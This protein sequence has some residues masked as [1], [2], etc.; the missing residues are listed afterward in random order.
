MALSKIQA[1]SMNLA[2][3]YA[4][5]GT[6]SGAGANTPAFRAHLGTNQNINNAS[7]TTMAFD[8][9]D[10]DTDN[11][12]NT[13][14]YRFTP[15][16]SGKYYIFAG[17]RY[18]ATANYDTD[19]DI[20]I[21]KNGSSIARFRGINYFQDTRIIQTITDMNGSTDYLEVTVYQTSGITQTIQSGTI[22]SYFGGF[23]LLGT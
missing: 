4:F 13:S 20:E 14:N 7:L 11:Y 15:L 5:T 1:E 23:K 3:T 6:V 18:T 19:I 8:T 2:D 12:F 21:R 17:Q 10:F 22:D 16:V 9:E